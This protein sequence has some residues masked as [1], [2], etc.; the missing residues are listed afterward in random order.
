MDVLFIILWAL[1]GIW[2]LAN[3]LSP[4]GLIGFLLF[5]ALTLLAVPATRRGSRP[6]TTSAPVFFASRWS[7]NNLIFPTQVAV[8]PTKVLRHKEKPIGAQEEAIN[9]TQIASV[10][11]D[12]GLLWSNVIIESTGGANPIICHGHLNADAQHMQ[13]LIQQYQDDYFRRTHSSSSGPEN[14]TGTTSDEL[15]LALTLTAPPSQPGGR[16]LTLIHDTRHLPPR[17]GEERLDLAIDRLLRQ[18]PPDSTI[19]I[20]S[21]PLS[22]PIPHSNFTQPGSNTSSRTRP[23]NARGRS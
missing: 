7:K 8:L 1:L 16:P 15:T 19:H 10:K 17:N 13:A 2:S 5:L 20:T 3:L 6:F 12:T 22:T 9:I 23:R 14:D 4:F 21:S 18:A 11:I